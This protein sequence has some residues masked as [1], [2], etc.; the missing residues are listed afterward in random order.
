[1]NFRRNQRWPDEFPK[2]GT[3]SSKNQRKILKRRYRKTRR[4]ARRNG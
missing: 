3:K 1:M 4:S 2:Q